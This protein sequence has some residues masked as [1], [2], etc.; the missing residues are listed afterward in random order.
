LLVASHGVDAASVQ[1]K[2]FTKQDREY[3]ALQPVR[4][5]DIPKVENTAW[6][7]NPIDAFIL[8][9]LEDKGIQPAVEADRTTLIRRV[10][11]DL[12]GLPPA[13][14]DVRAFLADT[15]AGAY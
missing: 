9:R 3:W 11:F 12:T 5:P 14:E 13:P 4:R 2:P 10:S 7:R 1:G 15:A 8:K 6:L